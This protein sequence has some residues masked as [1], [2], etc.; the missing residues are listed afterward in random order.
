MQGFVTADNDDVIGGGLSRFTPTPESVPDAFRSTH[1][2]NAR[3]TWVGGPSL[4]VEFRAR[5]NAGTGR[6]EP[7]PP[8]TA[9]GPPAVYDLDSSTTCCNSS[10]SREYRR[11]YTFSG[12]LGAVRGSRAVGGHDLRVGVEREHARVESEY[13]VPDR[14][15]SHDG[16]GPNCSGPPMSRDRLRSTTDRVTL[17]VQ[18]RW[19]LGR[20][21][22]IEPGLRLEW[23]MGS[24][25]SRRNVVATTAVAPRVGIA[26]DVTAQPARI[27]T[28]PLLAAT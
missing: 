22:T 5:G 19:T 14:G 20:N 24:V 27:V 18:D 25:P 8:A 17:F 10:L 6:R 7:H 15:V 23:N 16:P 28:R 13:G 21:V 26:W 9:G 11:S 2:W 4:L 1:A 12:A 3:T